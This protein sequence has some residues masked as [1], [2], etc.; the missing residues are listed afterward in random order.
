MGS[1]YASCSTFLISALE[2]EYKWVFRIKEENRNNMD[3]F[4]LAVCQAAS[5]PG[6]SGIAHRY[7]RDDR[8]FDH[9]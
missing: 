3:V 9:Q 4:Q 8:L 5:C 1:H 6:E 7:H 2:K